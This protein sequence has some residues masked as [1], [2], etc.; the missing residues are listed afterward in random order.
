MV[1]SARARDGEATII[2]SPRLVFANNATI[3]QFG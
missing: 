1:S 3:L 2:A